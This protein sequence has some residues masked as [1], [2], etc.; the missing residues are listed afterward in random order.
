MDE[1]F[2]WIDSI[3]VIQALESLRCKYGVLKTVAHCL[4]SKAILKTS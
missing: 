3:E 1:I 4:T 2:A